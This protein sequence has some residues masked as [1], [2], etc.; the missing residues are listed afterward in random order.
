MHYAAIQ[1]LLSG[2]M[3]ETD[4][5]VKVT[6]LVCWDKDTLVNKAKAVH[7]SNSKQFSNPQ[8]GRAPSLVTETWEDKH[9]HSELYVL[10]VMPHIQEYPLDQL[11]WAVLPVSPPNCLC[12]P[13]L[14]SGGVGW[15]ATKA[16]ALW[17]HCSAIMKISPYHPH[18]FQHSSIPATVRKI[19]SIP[20]KTSTFTNES[21]E[22]NPLYEDYGNLAR[23]RGLSEL[24][25]PGL[26]SSESVDDILHK[27]TNPHEMQM[28]SQWDWK[29][30]NLP[31]EE[32]I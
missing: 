25:M 23:R 32:N 2:G 5:R 11:G 12:T 27:F 18:Y 28:I 22:G 6:K 10:S 24:S 21:S 20:T 14:L 1:S 13:S 17:E 4:E 3:G 19:N 31:K 7:T 29:S 26:L 8:W 15:E 9:H 16:L 30:W